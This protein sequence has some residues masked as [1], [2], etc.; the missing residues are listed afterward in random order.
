[1]R[2][3]PFNLNGP[4]FLVFFIVFGTLIV[5]VIPL[6][7]RRSAS[8]ADDLAPLPR[9]TDPLEIATLRGGFEEAVR[10]VIVVLIDRRLL[11]HEN[12]G[13][14]VLPGGAAYLSA[15]LEMAVFRYFELGGSPSDVFHDLA[16]IGAGQAIEDSLEVR[17]L[18]V[19]GAKRSAVFLQSLAVIG[20]VA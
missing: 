14:G 6:I 20:S 7:Q 2:L 11:W 16:V 3:F 8:S 5:I 15:K 13:F 19:P 12:K 1:M 4:Q 17:G 18:R 10:L 9:L